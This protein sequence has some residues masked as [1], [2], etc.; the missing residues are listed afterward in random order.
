MSLQ[1]APGP[2]SLDR[3]DTAIARMQAKHDFRCL[4]DDNPEFP[5]G[6]AALLLTDDP[7][8]NLEVLDACVILPEAL[9][10][11]GDRISRH[12]A[13]PDMAPALM[14]KYG[15]A[16]APAVVF[17][18]DGEYVGSLN[19]IRDWNEYQ[20]EV[21]RLLSGPA[22]PKPIGIPVRVATSQGACA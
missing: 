7:Q 20:A 2:T 13:G 19:G 5:A 9:K 11:L 16:R 3:L 1:L 12:V 15:I 22:Q 21:D 4:T 10:P 6:L 8:R 18:R 14:Q 17:L